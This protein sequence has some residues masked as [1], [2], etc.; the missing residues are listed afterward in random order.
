M[1]KIALGIV[2]ILA[3]LLGINIFGHTQKSDYPDSEGWNR[4][5]LQGDAFE[6]FF[7]LTLTKDLFL[8]S[9]NKKGLFDRTRPTDITST[10]IEYRDNTKINLGTKEKEQPFNILAARRSFYAHRIFKDEWVFKIWAEQVSS[11]T[12]LEYKEALIHDFVKAG[13]TVD[14][15]KSTYKN[16]EYHIYLRKDL[17][18]KG[19]EGKNSIGGAYIFFPEYKI[20]LYLYFF[21]TRYKNP[22]AY[23]ITKDQVAN[24]IQEII[25]SAL[26]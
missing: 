5:P 7:P 21:N 23:M 3:I 14:I 17:T 12:F 25:D 13:S 8:G 16:H 9:V 24:V 4:K 15:E 10:F 26:N 6:K 22:D 1:W 18:P 11:E 20:S 19:L 2:A